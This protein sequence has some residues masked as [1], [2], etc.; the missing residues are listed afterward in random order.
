MD[1]GSFLSGTAPT[2]VTINAGQM[3]ALLTVAT[4]DDSTDEAGGTLTV[5]VTTGADYAVAAAPGNQAIV[6]GERQ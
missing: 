1:S 3:S 2:A 4:E 5:T 6:V